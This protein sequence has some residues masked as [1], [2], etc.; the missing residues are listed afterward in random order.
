MLSKY[1][2]KGRIQK[3]YLLFRYTYVIEQ[4]MLELVSFSN[5]YK[6]N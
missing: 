1:P 4:S 2:Y 5:V 6:R 3:R